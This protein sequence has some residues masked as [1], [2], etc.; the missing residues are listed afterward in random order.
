MLL[1]IPVKEDGIKKKDRNFYA[2][3]DQE[4]TGFEISGC[5]YPQYRV[6]M[7]L[8]ELPLEP[9]GQRFS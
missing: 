9:K 2:N 8:L 4:Y 6:R 7:L 5:N 1:V 3:P